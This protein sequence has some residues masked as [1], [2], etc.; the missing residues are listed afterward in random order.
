MDRY[1]I[2]HLD[3]YKRSKDMSI[4]YTSQLDSVSVK[5]GSDLGTTQGLSTYGSARD[6][7]RHGPD[8]FDYRIVHHFDLPPLPTT[9]QLS[10]PRHS[11]AEATT[12]TATGHEHGKVGD[13]GSHKLGCSVHEG[14]GV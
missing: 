2:T 14:R 1:G 6:A 10:I 11:V 5:R 9:A 13:V 7:P 3:G 8:F 12:R 4:V